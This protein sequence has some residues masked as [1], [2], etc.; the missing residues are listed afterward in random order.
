LRRG[1]DYVKVMSTGAR[2]VELEDPEP[3]QMTSEEITVAV[4]EAHRLGFR[5]AAH[6]EG[7]AGTELAINAGV[8]TIEHGM[9]L[10]RRP[11]LL[12]AMA[13]NGQTLVPT[14]SCFYAV[15]GIPDRIGVGD[16]D[17]AAP[18]WT[19]PLVELA[20]YNLEQADATLKAARAAGVNIALGHDWKPIANVGIELLRMIHHGLTASEALT[21]A[22]SG[23]AR[24]L[25]LAD[26]VGTVS[27]GRRA[28]LLVTDR[29]PLTQPGV[30]R[31]HESGWSSRRARPS[32]EPRSNVPFRREA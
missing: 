30:L 32:P 25:G 17:E 1:A 9:Y 20:R 16:P 24:A 23:A 3:A 21:A 29:D 4:E 8:D 31:D 19:P 26:H 7:L 13:E 27:V 15:A 11:D 10:S 22:T 14:L 18:S 6:A 2:S 5:V 12:E 28:D